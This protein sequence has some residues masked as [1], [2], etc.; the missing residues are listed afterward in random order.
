[1]FD[2]IKALEYLHN[3]SPQ[4]IH[5]DIKPEN[6]LINGKNLQIADFGWSNENDNKNVRNTFCG[7][8]D[9][10]APEM[11][12]GTG[13]NE[14]LDMWTVGILM[15]ELLHGKPPFT[16]KKKKANRRAQ[17][18]EIEKNILDGNM[19][20]NMTL[21][22]DSRDVM[23]ALLNGNKDLRPGATEVLDFAF[24]AR[25]RQALSRRSER[26]SDRSI[27]SLALEKENGELK[28]RLEQAEKVALQKTRDY[29]A[30][31]TKLAGVTAEKN[32]LETTLKRERMADSKDRG[33]QGAYFNSGMAKKSQDKGPR[34]RSRKLES[35]KF[36]KEVK[37]LKAALLNERKMTK[38]LNEEVKVKK[39]ELKESGSLNV[40]FFDK[41]KLM[42]NKIRSFYNTFCVPTNKEKLVNEQLDFDDMFKKLERVFDD[43]KLYRLKARNKQ[44][45][46][47]LH[48]G[49]TSYNTRKVP[50][51]ISSY[52]YLAPKEPIKTTTYSNNNLGAV[53]TYANA[54]K[55]PPI[56]NKAG[57]SIKDNHSANFSSKNNPNKKKSVGSTTTWSTKPS[58][59]NKNG[60]QNNNSQKLSGGTKQFYSKGSQSPYHRAS[61]SNGFVSKKKGYS[62]ARGGSSRRYTGK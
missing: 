59:G 25:R 5:R 46:S 19:D 28:A 18:R 21:S 9:Y 4:I 20:F 26:N 10:L 12:V 6:I 43:F 13:H 3:M 62:P 40:R 49:M 15:Y 37:D 31:E 24:F 34:S 48:E 33:R 30:L 47:N 42:S 44:S 17:Q 45:R 16:P 61:P 29:D 8:P 23:V 38:S 54:L 36:R 39:K 27:T 53:N 41:H 14:K 60:A 52:N 58:Y 7:T 35:E 22:K 32:S 57:R 1:M 50:E 2:I 55:K 56:N 11:I 51:G